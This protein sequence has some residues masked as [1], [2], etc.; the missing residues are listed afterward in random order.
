MIS[1][2]RFGVVVIMEVISVIQVWC[3]FEDISFQYEDM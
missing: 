2:C 1:V 3:G